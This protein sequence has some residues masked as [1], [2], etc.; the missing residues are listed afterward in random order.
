MQQQD[1]GAADRLTP[2]EIAPLRQTVREGYR[3]IDA[4]LARRKAAELRT[5]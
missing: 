4:V 1:E 5:P 2:A 3:E